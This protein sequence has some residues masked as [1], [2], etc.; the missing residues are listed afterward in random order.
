MP[1][2]RVCSTQSFSKSKFSQKKIHKGLGKMSRHFF[3][4]FAIV[5]SS[6]GIRSRK[7]SREDMGTEGSVRDGLFIFLFLARKSRY[8]KFKGEKCKTKPEK[9]DRRT[10]KQKMNPPR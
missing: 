1:E 7:K 4:V 3:S 5:K 10:R 6:E 2:N 9:W 8:W